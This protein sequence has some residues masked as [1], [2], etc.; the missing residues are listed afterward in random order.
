MAERTLTVLDRH[1]LTKV[2]SRY[3]AR[4]EELAW[5][6][7]TN[8]SRSTRAWEW[9]VLGARL[10]ERLV[11][12]VF[13]I[14]I[15][16]TGYSLVQ[17]Q[18][19]L[20]T[21]LGELENAK[22]AAGEATA[23]AA[24]LAK[25]AA[26]LNSALE[27][28]T[29]QRYEFQTKLDQATIEIKSARTQLEDKQSRLVGMQSELEN[30]KQ[31]ADEATAQAAELA[32][33]AASLNSALE[34]AKA[35][36]NDGDLATSYVEIGDV[37]MAQGNLTEALKWYRDGLA[38]ADRLVKADPE[39]VGRRRDLSISHIKIGDV[40]TTQ[41]D[42]TEALKTYQESLAIRDRLAKADFNNAN[43]QRDLAI[44]QG[45]VAVVLAKQGDAPRA[46]DELRRGRA[47]ISRLVKQSPENG[48]LF[49]DLAAFDQSIATLEQASVPE[50]GSAKSVQVAPPDKKR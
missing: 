4:A 13:V 39:N 5:R 29:A 20:E 19:H 30:A 48:Q 45:R 36:G 15:I 43:R 31:A 49:K 9:I 40:L 18:Q 38:V 14:L 24:E 12:A 42:L 28:A 44:S 27:K 33:R 41:G 7:A 6:R 50:T 37:L 35:L 23:Q 46:L 21:S 32:K 47:I 8:R 34:K 1:F 11:G 2:A 17:T 22:Q 3:R 25:R 10:V 16:V 26:S